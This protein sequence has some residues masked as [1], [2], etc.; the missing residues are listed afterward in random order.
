MAAAVEAGLRIGSLRG[1]LPPR[2]LWPL[3]A[4][5][6]RVCV[7]SGGADALRDLLVESSVPLA[8]PGPVERACALTSLAE[9]GRL[10]G[11][12][13]VVA[14]GAAVVAWQAIGNL[15]WLVY[16][17]MRQ[18]S[19]GLAAGQRGAATA[20]LRRAAQLARQL[21]AEPLSAQLNSV[22]NRGRVEIWPDEG[23]APSA[24]PQGLTA[25]EVEVLALLVEGRSN[26]EI[27]AALFIS[28]KTVSVH[29]S[30]I[31]AKL[32]VPSRGAAA[33]AAHRLGLVSAV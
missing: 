33:A 7:E 17:L 28:V 6:W 18:G 4:H 19:A 1:W 8:Q 3:I 26:R 29:V 5:A 15:P 11:A 23:G 31:L 30:N 22:A 10:G 24:S 20:A 27:A 32:E 25:R 16:A 2:L 14:W 21:G 9:R 13:D 12:S